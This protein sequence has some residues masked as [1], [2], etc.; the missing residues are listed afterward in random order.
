MYSLEVRKIATRLY[1]GKTT[2]RQVAMIIGSSH[3]S[4]FRWLHSTPKKR[5]PRPRKLEKPEILDAIELF[6]KTN[7]TA[8]TD[9]ILKKI[10]ETFNLKVSRE[11]VR[12]TLR[13]TLNYTRK[14]VR[15]FSK[16][17]NDDQKLQDFLEK[18][19]VFIS[20]GRTFVSIDETSFGRNYLPTSGY[21]KKGERLYC[22][23]P[24]V[25]TK[26]KSVLAAV[27][28]SKDV[29]YKIKEGSY[30]SRSFCDFLNKLDYPK[31]TVIL[32]DN[33]SF[34]HSKLVKELIKSKG[35]DTLYTPPYSPIFNPIE[36]VFS[37]VKRTYSKVM[38]IVSSFKSISDY[39][40]RAFFY[41]SFK[42]ISR[43]ESI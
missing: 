37:I 5:E 20:Q 38:N 3:S 39:H 34:H 9:D 27:S 21:S 30:D 4:I 42:A 40:V 18:R 6:I 13:K 2:L 8:G 31:N 15:Y 29:T 1:N 19:K 22:K 33:V 16:P 28:P 32:M 43:F 36:G 26:T 17:K 10:K 41:H 14:R 35:W 11:L 7:P 24:W 25:N 12:L 23:R